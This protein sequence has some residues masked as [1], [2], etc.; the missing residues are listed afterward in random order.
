MFQRFIWKVSHLPVFLTNFL[1]EVGRISIFLYW[2]TGQLRCECGNSHV[3]FF[4]VELEIE[5]NNWRVSGR[6]IT[7]EVFRTCF[8][9]PPVI[10]RDAPRIHH[11]RVMPSNPPAHWKRTAAQRLP[12][13]CDPRHG[14]W[15]V[16]EFPPVSIQLDVK[17]ILANALCMFDMFSRKGAFTKRSLAKEMRWRWKQKGKQSCW[18]EVV[19]QVRINSS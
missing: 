3:F 19:F 9:H 2:I 17:S 5:S 12:L 7:L 8:F 18:D 1:L 10:Q 14:T 11:V 16:T 4:Q 6:I 15:G 13:H